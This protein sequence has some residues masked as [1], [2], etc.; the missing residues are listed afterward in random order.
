MEKKIFF[1]FNGPGVKIKIASTA[2]GYSKA[3]TST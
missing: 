3:S 2:I 1:N